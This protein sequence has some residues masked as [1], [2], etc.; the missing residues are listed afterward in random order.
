MSTEVVVADTS[1][2]IGLARI[3]QLAL[4]PALFGRITIPRAVWEEL[5]QGAAEGRAGARDV[6]EASWIDVRAADPVAA[7]AYKLLVDRGEAEALALAS[8]SPDALLI[9]D[10]RRGRRIARERGVRMVGTLG[11]LVLARRRNLV[12]KLRPL[13]DALQQ[14]G[15]YLS[16]GVLERVL[17]EVGE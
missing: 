15:I 1:P 5:T 14:A 10:D 13:L 3:G 17:R 4:L 16:A 8:A 6:Q 9:I 12:P 7:A 2:L 11:V